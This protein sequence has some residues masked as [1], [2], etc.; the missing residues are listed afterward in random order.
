MYVY[1][2]GKFTMEGGTIGG[3]DGASANSS[4]SGGGVCVYKGVFTMSDGSISRNTATDSGGGVF[5]ST[6]GEFTM[7]G[8]TIG[9]T[10]AG[11]AN[12]ADN[13][14]GVFVM[15]GTFEMSGTAAIR[16][17][18]SNGGGG[19]CVSSSSGGFTM[20]GGTI[21]GTEANAANRADLG[22]GVYVMNFGTVTMNDGTI[23]ENTATINGED[24]YVSQNCYFN[25]TGGTV[26]KIYQEP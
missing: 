9:G 18:S 15:N 19:V 4:E 11:S 24:V 26:D 7:T 23:S 17:N 5:V 14:G 25:K 3:S 16:G 13:G 2:T 6:G 20:N 1:E 22:G 8:G 21:G 12:T 10:D